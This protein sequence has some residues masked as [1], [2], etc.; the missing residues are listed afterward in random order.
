MSTKKRIKSLENPSG[1][2]EVYKDDNKIAK[3]NYN[4]NVQQ[5]ILI[6][7]TLKETS[8]IEGLKFM[9]G[10]ISALEGTKDLWGIDKLV[11]HMQDGR[12]VDFFIKSSDLVSGN[13]QIQ[14]SGDFY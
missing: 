11:L 6:A 9:T 2:G 4:L 8:E 10:S 14:P 1:V 12:K 3:V 7:E 5:E 13:F